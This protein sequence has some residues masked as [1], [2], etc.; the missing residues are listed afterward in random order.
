MAETGQQSIA[1]RLALPQIADIVEKL[2][3]PRPAENTVRRW[4]LRGV[5]GVKLGAKRC[6]GRWYVDEESLKRFLE[7][8]Q[9]ASVPA[10]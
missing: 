4:A 5:R 2:G 9:A 3:F 8:V 1:E 7:Q 10:A 6:G